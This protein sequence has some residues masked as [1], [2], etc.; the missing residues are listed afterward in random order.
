MAEE[1]DQ[2]EV[3]AQILSGMLGSGVFLHYVIRAPRE[4]PDFPAG[5]EDSA[6]CMFYST[7]SCAVKSHFAT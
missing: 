6:E 2:I 7:D 5:K 4:N 3:C 1:G